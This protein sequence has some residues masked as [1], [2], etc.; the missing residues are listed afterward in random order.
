MTAAYDTI[1]LGY[2]QNSS[3]RGWTNE[4]IFMIVHKRDSIPALVKFIVD[5]HFKDGD[6]D[7]SYKHYVPYT[8]IFEQIIGK[9]EGKKTRAETVAIL[10]DLVGNINPTYV[11]EEK[12]PLNCRVQFDSWLDEAIVALCDWGQNIFRARSEGDGNGTKIDKPLPPYSPGLPV[13]L[14]DAYGRYSAVGLTSL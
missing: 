5:N 6:W 11:F 4:I 9:I 3:G 13:R 14:S 7:F 12:S 8:D 2:P 1:D 10:T